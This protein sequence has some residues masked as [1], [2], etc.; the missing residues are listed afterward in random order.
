[1]EKRLERMLRRYGRELT[2]SGS[3]RT[4][5]VLGFW[6]PVLG[7]G[8]DTAQKQTGPAGEEHRAR[9]RCIVSGRETLCRKDVISVDDREYLVRSVRVI[10]GIGGPLYCR[11]VC[12]EKGSE[13]DWGFNG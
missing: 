12:V 1:M 8:R 6:Q 10:W 5:K 4:R 3:D 13:D 2:V 9:Y 11:A 7:Q